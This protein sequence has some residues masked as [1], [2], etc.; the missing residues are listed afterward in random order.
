MLALSP[1]FFY[2]FLPTYSLLGSSALQ[3]LPF[4]VGVN[5]W[6]ESVYALYKSAFETLL[7]FPEIHDDAEEEKFTKVLDDL[8]ENF[9]DVIPRLAKGKKR[10]YQFLYI[11]RFI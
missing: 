9:Q 4:I 10:N 6:I 7:Q 5:P 2:R 1:E 11:I 3:G 8:V